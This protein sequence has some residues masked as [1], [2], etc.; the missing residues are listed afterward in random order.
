[1]TNILRDIFITVVIAL[2]FVGIFISTSNYHNRA[3]GFCDQVRAN[4][5]ER[6][7]YLDYQIFCAD[8]AK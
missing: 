1:M 2:I 8:E 6:V 5:A 3:G 4:N 7:E